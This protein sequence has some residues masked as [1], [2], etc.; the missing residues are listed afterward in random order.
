MRVVAAPGQLI[1]VG[2][3]RLHL[4]CQGAGNPSVD[5]QRGARRILPQLDLRSAG[6]SRIRPRLCGRSR[7]I[8]V[9]R[10]RARGRGRRARI[11]DELRTLAR[12]RHRPAAVHPGRALV[13]RFDGFACS[14]TDTPQ[15][16]RVSSLLDPAYPEDWTSHPLRL[17]VTLVRR[18]ARSSA[19]TPASRPAS[20]LTGPG[21]RASL[22]PAPPAPRVVTAFIA[23]RGALRRVDEEVM[24]PAAKLAR[25]IYVK[26]SQR[27]WTNPKF[28]DAL[29]SPNRCHQRKRGGGAGRS[30][31]S[32]TC[33]WSWSPARRTRTE[34]QLSRQGPACR[35]IDS[36]PPRRRR[37]ERPLDP[38]RSART[39]S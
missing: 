35:A 2:G 13:R 21:R 10:R 26:S 11:V 8:R 39:S 7:G 4:Y 33:R 18:G 5:V 27:F 3:H 25:P 14:S 12:G 31:T 15:V 36:R 22:V 16:W 28:F 37:A 32:A 17:S 24:A 19:A 38:A 34:G 23:S 9:E 30:R 29:G 6:N 20:A 1:D